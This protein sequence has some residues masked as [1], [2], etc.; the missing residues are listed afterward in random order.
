MTWLL[1]D[2]TASLASCPALKHSKAQL[3]F[4]RSRY[5]LL[6][7]H[8]HMLIPPCFNLGSYLSFKLHSRMTSSGKLSLILQNDLLYS[9]RTS[10]CSYHKSVYF[11]S[12]S[13][14]WS[15]DKKFI[16]HLQLYPKKALW[17]PSLLVPWDKL[18]NLFK[19]TDSPLKYVDST[20]T[21]S[22]CC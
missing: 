11:L 15:E 17:T 7:L 21:H 19:P 5:C 20:S 18:F 10:Q 16:N 22:W 12:V 2:F 6:F 13:F 4:H 3:W 9:H 8:F 1:P 14:S